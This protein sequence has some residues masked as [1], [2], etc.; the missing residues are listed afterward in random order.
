[1]QVEI[2][3]KTFS[4]GQVTCQKFSP[5][6]GGPETKLYIFWPNFFSVTNHYWNATEKF[7]FKFLLKSYSSTNKVHRRAMLTPL[8]KSWYISVA[9]NQRCTLSVSHSI[10][11]VSDVG[12]LEVSISIRFF[13][14]GREIIEKF[15]L[16]LSRKLVHT[17]THAVYIT[18]VKIIGKVMVHKTLLMYRK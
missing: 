17:H 1:M 13:P 3:K 5:I 14:T 15:I 18:L 2:K 6:G 4:C 7:F 16:R 11:N 9:H 10:K 8:K 12:H